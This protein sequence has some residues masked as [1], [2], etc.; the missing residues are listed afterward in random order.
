MIEST[1]KVSLQPCQKSIS[2]D[3]DIGRG[4]LLGFNAAVEKDGTGE[5]SQRKH[6]Y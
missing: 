3:V 1:A 6:V 4:I 2:N 5:G